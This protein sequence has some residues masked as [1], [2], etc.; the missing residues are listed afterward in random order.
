MAYDFVPDVFKLSILPWS[1]R[2]AMVFDFNFAVSVF[3]EAK[4]MWWK[5]EFSVLAV[6]VFIEEKE[7]DEC[8]AF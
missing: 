2:K 1:P 6:S 8:L 3:T 7:C 4:R 5:T